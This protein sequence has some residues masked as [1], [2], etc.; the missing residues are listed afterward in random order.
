[1]VC[2][3][4]HNHPQSEIPVPSTIIRAP[5]LVHDH[6]LNALSEVPITTKS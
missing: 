3:H 6:V 4:I 1:M 2:V 5:F